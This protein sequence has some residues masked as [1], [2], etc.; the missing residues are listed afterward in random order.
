[1]P[2]RPWRLVVLTALRL[3]RS[4]RLHLVALLGALILARLM[5]VA[6]TGWFF[7]AAYSGL[8]TA[9][10]LYTVVARSRG[11][12][13]YASSTLT[14]PGALL[15]LALG[16]GAAAAATSIP[17]SL[18]LGTQPQLLTIVAALLLGASYTLIV[19]PLGTTLPLLLALYLAAKQ[20][21][22]PT[23]F[24]AVSTVL[25][26]ATLPIAC[27]AGPGGLDPRKRLPWT[28]STGFP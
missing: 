23:A 28:R 4:P 24:I 15:L 18:A 7:P 21:G 25:A 12:L 20:G 5:G 13:E 27:I 8:A 9:I 17:V 3:L 6:R 14:C 26:L 19:M 22:G 2:L 11:F 10:A 1:M 16:A